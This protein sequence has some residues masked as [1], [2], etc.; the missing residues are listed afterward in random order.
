MRVGPGA[1][2]IW[3]ALFRWRLVKAAMPQWTVVVEATPDRT[4]RPWP[5]EVEGVVLSVMV[6]ARAVEEAEGLAQL[7]IFEEGLNPITADAN[8]CEPC[9]APSLEPQAVWRSRFAFF[10][11]IDDDPPS[12]P[13][14]S[15]ES[16]K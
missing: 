3:R 6:W 15:R 2:V 8:P 1:G 13:P 9:C 5:E 16:Q 12:K 14:L 11:R 10:G 7:A 4:R